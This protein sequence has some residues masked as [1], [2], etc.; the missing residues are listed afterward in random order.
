M[1][2]R[3]DDEYLASLDANDR[4]LTAEETR[5]FLRLGTLD[6]LDAGYERLRDDED[7]QR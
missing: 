4:P 7:D 6:N 1:S 3:R 5:E 2:R